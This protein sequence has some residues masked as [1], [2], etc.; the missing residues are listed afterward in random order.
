M[1]L[2]LSGVAN[3]NGKQTYM[4][5]SKIKAVMAGIN[6]FIQVYVLCATEHKYGAD[7]RQTGHLSFCC[8]YVHM[9]VGCSE[10]F[11]QTA[12]HYTLLL[13]CCLI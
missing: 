13:V 11:R 6:I 4:Q 2:K 12:E 3:R 5:S 10:Y 9:Y 1:L 8:V 7:I